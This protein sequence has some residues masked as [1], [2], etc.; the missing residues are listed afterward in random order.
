MIDIE[1]IILRNVLTESR[2]G[3]IKNRYNGAKL[4][5]KYFKIRFS[6]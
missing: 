4:I 5:S 6:N 1:K 2:N 3:G